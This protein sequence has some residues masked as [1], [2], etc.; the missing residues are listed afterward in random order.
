M[1]DELAKKLKDAG[2]KS[3][4]TRCFS[5]IDGMYHPD[6]SDLIESCGYDFR[7][8]TYHSPTS[9]ESK[10]CKYQV[11]G[12]LSKLGHWMIT[13]GWTPEEAVAKL[14]IAINKKS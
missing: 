3:I 2:Y 12:G 11:K 14:W 13:S 7:Q 9:A 4:G 6:L 5:A 8:L 10:G 1:N